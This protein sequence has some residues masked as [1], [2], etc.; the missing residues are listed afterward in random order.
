MSKLWK[1]FQTKQDSDKTSNKDGHYR[2][3]IPS[4]NEGKNML[5][6]STSHYCSKNRARTR[7][8]IKSL[9]ISYLRMTQHIM[10]TVSLSGEP[11][12]TLCR[13]L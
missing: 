8:E 1:I 4:D 12:F 5:E 3:A 2:D 7:I 9:W 10:Y 13:Y 6:T 11:L